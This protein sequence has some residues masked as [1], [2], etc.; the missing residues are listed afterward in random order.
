M[1]DP[2]AAR[3]LAEGLARL[4]TLAPGGTKWP[5]G[6][7]LPDEHHCYAVIGFAGYTF[8]AGAAD[9]VEARER[10]ADELLEEAEK[11][12]GGGPV[13]PRPELVDE[14][15]LALDT[16]GPMGALPCRTWPG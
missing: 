16:L 2:T 14:D 12:A 8:Y 6:L 11:I 1:N 5:G 15:P 3:L 7:E 10:L 9:V 13:G 4:A